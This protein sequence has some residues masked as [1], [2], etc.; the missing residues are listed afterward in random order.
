MVQ[1]K[2]H[3]HHFFTLANNNESK[4]LKLPYK[5]DRCY[6]YLR[7][8]GMPTWDST[9]TN[10]TLFLRV[11]Q[12]ARNSSLNNTG[13]SIIATFVKNNN[14]AELFT[15]SNRI[16]VEDLQQTTM[17]TFNIKDSAGVELTTASGVIA[18]NF[19]VVEI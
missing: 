17:L 5:L 7:M 10:K 12:L 2:Y 16:Y 8:V 9:S 18:F 3:G 19:E 6:I 14:T 11:P 1:N 4:E 15:D 13:D